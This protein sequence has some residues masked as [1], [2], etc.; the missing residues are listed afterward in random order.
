M[1]KALAAKLGDPSSALGI[2]VMQIENE[3]IRLM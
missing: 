3:P 2:H 1:D